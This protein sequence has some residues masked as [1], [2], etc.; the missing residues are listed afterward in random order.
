MVSPRSF[1]VR[2]R[3]H[4]GLEQYRFHP[5]RSCRQRRPARFLLRIS[6]PISQS[7]RVHAVERHLDASATPRNTCGP[8]R[9][10][11][12]GGFMNGC[13]EVSS[14]AH[15]G[16]VPPRNTPHFLGTLPG[17][18]T[19]VHESASRR[20][21]ALQR[22]ASWAWVMR[23]NDAFLALWSGARQI[24]DELTTMCTPGIDA[25]ILTHTLHGKPACH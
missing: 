12:H 23:R 2:V 25:F 4:V 22:W 24:G 11:S 18:G 21:P 14:V 9:S 15:T 7:P 19:D 6:Q 13:A 1:P 8:A 17:F 5:T 20:V 10:A 16:S 3:M